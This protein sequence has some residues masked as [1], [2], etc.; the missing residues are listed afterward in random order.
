MEKALMLLAEKIAEKS[1]VAVVGVKK[2]I[3]FFKKE[4]VKKGLDYVK[5]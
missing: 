2:T 1:P 4:S 5:T 3:D